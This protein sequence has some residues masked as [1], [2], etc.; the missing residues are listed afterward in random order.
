MTVLRMQNRF[1][2]V[3]VLGALVWCLVVVWPSLSGRASII[4]NQENRLLDIRYRLVGPVLPARDL[5]IV[6]IDDATLSSAL[7][8]EMTRRALLAL[9]ITHI[10]QSGAK[11]LALDVLLADRGDAAV[12]AAL[13][14]ALSR[15]PSVIAAAA[16]FEPE[17]G[18]STGR[19]IWPLATFT[20]AAQAGAVNVSS[21]ENGV[22]RYIPLLVP[23]D[24]TLV[25]SLPLLA[26]LSFSGQASTFE[27][28]EL[29]LGT[30]RVPID[31]VYN[32][33]LRAL[34]PTGTV[35]T[36]SA[37]TLLQGPLADTLSNKIVVLGFT[38][39]A[40]GDRFETPFSPDTPGVE[41]I[42]SAISQLLQSDTLQRNR[43]TRLWDAAHAG[44]LTLAVVAAICLLPLFGGV[45]AALGLLGISFGITAVFLAWG[46]WLS[47]ALPLAAAV[48]PMLAV[49]AMR[50]G[51]ERAQARRSERSAASLRRFQ[52]P[53]LA[54]RIERDPDYLV[55]PQEQELAVFFVDLTGFTM[56]SQQLGPEGTQQLL[57]HFHKLTT[58][59]VEGAGGSVFNYMG[60]GALAIFGL[61]APQSSTAADHALSAAFSLVR[62]L[63]DA[64]VGQV[65]HERLHCR[66]GLHKGPA[67]LS[68]LGAAGYQ[69]VTASGDTVNLA[70]RLMEVAK[71]QDAVIVASA[72][73]C[74]ALQQD[75]PM[76]QAT[77]VHVP[78]RGRA[79]DVHVQC[80][81]MAQVGQLP[82]SGPGD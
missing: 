13:T 31:N 34:G 14:R 56:L 49:G 16:V 25:P 71:A 32:M 5:V 64:R 15:V 53:A 47:A 7:G 68:R 69:Q 20:S 74:A 73:F 80:W 45:A 42:A 62:L 60:D 36:L 9:L 58:K 33:P 50:Y 39:T 37:Q 6:A 24:G 65:P 43:D 61:D 1:V 12:D 23:V 63:A 70:S 57:S 29:I 27:G 28:P 79:G 81:T 10:S 75:A 3:A 67:T 54:Q 38:A 77:A 17:A 2:V 35:P 41:V 19:M 4:D 18:S 26:A 30:R 22:P 40:T 82:P 66:I 11:T 44:L 46:V 76:A 55:Q 48:P 59:A 52:S 21:D 8:G 51:S 72:A 78:I